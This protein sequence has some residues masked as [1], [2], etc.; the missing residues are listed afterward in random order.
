M[1]QLKS[2]QSHDTNQAVHYVRKSQSQKDGKP[3]TRCGYKSHLRKDECPA[4]GSTCSVCGKANHWSTACRQAQDP[5]HSQ[6]RE[7][8]RQ[9]K[10]PNSARKQRNPRHQNR[11]VHEIT[12]RDEFSQL[13]INSLEV[14]AVQSTSE[15]TRDE[16][17]TYLQTKV[18]KSKLLVN[19]R[20]KVDTGAQG[21]TLPVR[22]FKE[23]FPNS[24]TP[25]GLPQSDAVT[26]T[27]MVLTAYNGTIIKQH[28]C[29]ELPCR[30]G[31]S[32]WTP[33][34]FFVVE[35][36]GPAIVGLP[37]SRQLNLVTLHCAITATDSKQKVKEVDDLV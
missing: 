18:D 13:T 35:S 25:E 17:F 4:W 31:S 29:V 20:V 19:L 14:A 11:S 22:M 37:S 2:A 28:G 6:T 23:M 7:K 21:N 32:S 34:K 10:Q 26:Q 1:Q 30:F 9:N 5:S 8:Q 15:D 27:D 36:E 33:T 16:V 3:C 12:Q 24:L